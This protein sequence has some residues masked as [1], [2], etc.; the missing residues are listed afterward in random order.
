MPLDTHGANFV[1]C[2]GLVGV[3]RLQKVVTSA[4]RVDFLCAISLAHAAFENA[5]VEQEFG[6]SQS[7]RFE[8]AA[9]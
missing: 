4:R 7:N 3:K 9:C 2:D 8:K 6:V 1:D 5:D